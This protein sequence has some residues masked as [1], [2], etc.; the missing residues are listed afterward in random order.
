MEVH[1]NYHSSPTSTGMLLCAMSMVLFAASMY[2][3]FD[4]PFAPDS[5]VSSY[6]ADERCS[7]INPATSFAGRYS[8]TT[9]IP[10][11]SI[12]FLVFLMIR[13][14]SLRLYLRN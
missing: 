8:V 13:Y 5:I 14:V 2:V 10:L 3:L 4:D 7:K 9:L 11:S 1:E 12:P 6:E